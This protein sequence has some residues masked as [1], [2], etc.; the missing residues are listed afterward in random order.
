MSNRKTKYPL[1]TMQDAV[2]RFADG[3]SVSDV[4]KSLGVHK[5]MIYSWNHKIT[6]GK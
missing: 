6:T 2:K 4:A 1:A 3:E 5:S